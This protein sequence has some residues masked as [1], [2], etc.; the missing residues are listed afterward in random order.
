MQGAAGC[1]TRTAKLLLPLPPKPCRGPP[2]A[3]H[4]QQ[5]FCRRDPKQPFCSCALLPKTSGHCMSSCIKEYSWILCRQGLA[6]LLM[7]R[8]AACLD[9]AS[10]SAMSFLSS[11]ANARPVLV[12]SCVLESSMCNS[13]ILRIE[14]P[15]KL[16]CSSC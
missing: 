2:G 11:A 13:A 15:Y 3:L 9:N 1:Y 7:R 6:K 4:E 8:L 10:N 5:G 16:W 14:I 12:R